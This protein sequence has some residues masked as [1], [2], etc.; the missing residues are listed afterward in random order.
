MSHPRLSPVSRLSSAIQRDD[1]TLHTFPREPRKPGLYIYAGGPRTASTGSDEVLSS[2]RGGL[3]EPSLC[4][5]GSTHS[6]WIFPWDRS[7]TSRPRASARPPFE[8]RSSEPESRRTRVGEVYMGN[9]LSAG[10]RPGAGAPGR[11]L[12]AGIPERGPG[13]HREQGLRIGPPGG[14]LRRQVDRS[15]RR[16]RR[17]RRRHGVDVQRALLPAQGAHA[18]TAW[19]T[20][21]SSTA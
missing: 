20:A 21:R 2:P 14:D 10:D 17:R 7:V 13:H 11:H 15:R 16:G 6:G 9:V 1:S 18:A 12:T 4:G 19:A 8:A 3:F 5:R